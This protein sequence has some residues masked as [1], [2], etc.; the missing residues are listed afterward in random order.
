[1][2][3]SLFQI[4]SEPLQPEALKRHLLHSHA[5][6]LATFEGW[7]RDHNGGQPVERLEYSSYAQLANREGQRIVDEALRRFPIDGALARHR[8]GLL[9]VGDIAVWVGATAAHRAAAFEAC[10]YLIEEIKGRVPIWKREYYSNGATNW[11]NCHSE[12]KSD[13]SEDDN[14]R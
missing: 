6:A 7:V 9:E 2:P 12:P 1:M 4:D 13:P 8:T 3:Q 14:R 11:V 10:R 5:G